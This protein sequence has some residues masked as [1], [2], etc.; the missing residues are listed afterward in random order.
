MADASADFAYVLAG[1][2]PVLSIFAPAP[3]IFCSA[4]A[5]L[6]MVTAIFSSV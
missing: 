6:L 3:S 1:A 4:H 2:D 5:I